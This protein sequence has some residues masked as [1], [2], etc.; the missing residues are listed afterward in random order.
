MQSL[1]P[2]DAIQGVQEWFEQSDYRQ[3]Q[4]P[5][6]YQPSDYG[7]FAAGPVVHEGFVP[8]PGGEDDDLDDYEDSRQKHYIDD[9]DDDYERDWDADEELR[10]IEDNNDDPDRDSDFSM[11]DAD[12]QEEEDPDDMLIDEEEDEE[13][14]KSKRTRGSARGKARGARG[15]KTRGRPRARGGRNGMPKREKTRKGPRI[16]TDPGPEFKTLQSIA[17]EAYVLKQFP[18]AIEY[19]TKAVQLNPEIY[20]AHSLLSEI[21]AEMGHEQ[22]ALEALFLG[23]PTKRDKDL[24]FHII[25]RIKNID[26]EEYPTYDETYKTHRILECLRGILTVDSENYEARSEKLDIEE[27]LGNTGRAVKLCQK[28]LQIRPDDD[29]VL[30]RMARIGTASKTKTP[31]YM[32]RMVDAFDKSIDHFMANDEPSSSSL[33]WSMLNIYLDLLLFAEQYERGLPRLKVIARWIQHRRNETYWDDETDD[34]EFDVEDAPRR[35]LVPDF[36]RISPTTRYGDAFP[37]EIRAKLGIFRVRQNPP[38]LAE[39]MHHLGMLEPDDVGV[40]AIVHDYQDLFRD[41]A[42]ALYAVGCHPEALQFY[43]ALYN[44]ARDTLTLKDHFGMYAGFQ[45]TEQQDRAEEFLATLR[46]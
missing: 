1:I 42:D 26:P 15:G 14:G 22:K 23:A 30:R 16:V 45:A 20:G 7:S 32:R 18:R 36:M 31:E 13:D 11:A 25:E 24:W 34:R 3:N 27:L 4:G 2:Q 46:S 41:A 44:T 5:P 33:D 39:G 12:E 9:S 21:Y 43:D 19:A 37:L 40:D 10:E 6:G 8:A 38:D 17:S 28:M 35:I 29:D